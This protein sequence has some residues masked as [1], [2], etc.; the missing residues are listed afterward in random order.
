[1]L[2]SLPPKA[3]DLRERLLAFM[4][5]YVY[6]AEPV[7]EQWVADNNAAEW[8]EPPVLAELKTRARDQGL[9]N[10][11]LD[12]GAG[13]G[14]VDY[15]HLVEIT[16]RSPDLAPTAING[17]APDSVNMVM[18]EAAA[19]DEQRKRWLEPLQNDEF[20]SAFAMTEPDVASS[21]ATN[22]S[23]S[24]VRDGDSYVLNGRKWYISGTM[25]PRCEILFVMGVTNPDMP[26]HQRQSIIGVPVATPGVEVVRPMSVFG[27]VGDHAE[28]T[29]TDVRVPA[30]NLL[31]S[32]G[33]GFRI[34][35]T[36]L[37]AA[38]L[39][40]SMR[41]VGLAERAL[42]L[43]SARGSERVV[44]GAPLSQIGTFR[45]Q[46]AECRLAIDQARLITLQAASTADEL[47]TAGAQSHLAMSKIAATRMALAVI[48]R[49][50]GM[51]GAKGVSQDTPLARWWAN[52]RGLHI[53]DGPEEVHLELVARAELGRLA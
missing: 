27:Y 2:Y 7:A 13:L 20:K 52:A 35:Q 17:G 50:I 44:F 12:A 23:C 31:G 16:G 49:A 21:D 4:D 39:H 15:A 40:H 25:R 48:D 5:D 43:A 19:N 1:M 26:R 14:H 34:A 9:W 28:I 29:F 45:N 10:L 53:A 18:L 33:Q 36:R 30:A 42:S 46:I 32:E 3:T 8:D 11:Y 6:P 51:H 24:I 22:I 47:G 41:L 38:R 37:A